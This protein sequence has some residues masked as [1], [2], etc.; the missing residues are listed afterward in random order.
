MHRWEVNMSRGAEF[1]ASLNPSARD[2]GRRHSRAF[3][4][5]MM[6]MGGIGIGPHAMA[7][8]P[9]GCDDS[10]SHYRLKT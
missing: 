1:A 4:A 2:C 9:S 6:V 8:A 5:A 3:Y 10:A 7:T